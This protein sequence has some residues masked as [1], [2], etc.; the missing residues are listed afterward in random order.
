MRAGGASLP[1]VVLVL[2]GV[3]VG[4]CTGQPAVVD[5]CAMGRCDVDTKDGAVA[6]TYP[7]DAA[8]ALSDDASVTTDGSPTDASPSDG[9]APVPRGHCCL[10][11]TPVSCLCPSGDA[12]GFATI[13]ADGTC[14]DGGAVCAEVDGG[15]DSSGD[16]A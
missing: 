9:P 15:S 10:E 6:G 12:C 13:C 2:G 11:G 14:V 5:P 8:D 4:S 3:S 1:V 16:G 7:E